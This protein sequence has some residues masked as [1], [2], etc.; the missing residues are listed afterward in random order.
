MLNDLC[1]PLVGLLELIYNL[2]RSSALA[3][4]DESNCVE[5]LQIRNAHR[6]AKEHHRNRENQNG[7][8]EKEVKG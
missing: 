8:K 4:F 7:T 2:S 5:C 1:V 3:P 6:K